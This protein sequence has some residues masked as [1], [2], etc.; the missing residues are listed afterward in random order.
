MGCGC[1]GAAA[2]GSEW[3]IRYADGTVSNR[4]PDE[5]SAR[6]ALARSGKT[7]IVKVAK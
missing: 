4:Y 6:I 1:Q 2:A 7:G 5:S 3:V